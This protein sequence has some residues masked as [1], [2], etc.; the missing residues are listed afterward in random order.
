VALAFQWPGGRCAH[1]G[2]QAI[3]LTWR[4]VFITPGETAKT[5]AGVLAQA[6]ARQYS[7]HGHA[8]N[9]S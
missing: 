3:R 7:L 8:R 1:E 5:F 9:G 6:R 2:W 4:M